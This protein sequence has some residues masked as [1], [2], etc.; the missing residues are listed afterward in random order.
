MKRTMKY[1][2]LALVLLLLGAGPGLASSYTWGDYGT[3]THDTPK[4]QDLATYKAEPTYW[5]RT[6]YTKTSDYGVWWNV[7]G[8]GWTQDTNVVLTAG[9]TV[10]FK[11]NMH[12]SSVGTHYADFAK[13]WVDWGQDGSFDE[14]RYDVGGDVVLF[15]FEKLEDN[16]THWWWGDN[17]GSDNT[18]WNPYFSF[19]SDAIKLTD[20]IYGDLFLRARVT[21][22]ESLGSQSP[23]FDYESN[24]L[25]SGHLYQG[26]TEDWKLTATPVPPSLL[27]F[28]TGLIGF[29]AANRKRFRKA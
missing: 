29:A 24:F 18:P 13:L 9:S 10:Q 26:E 12:K 4:W 16:E 8:T 6:Q 5:G 22:S 17:R 25:A 19:T 2:A 20:S 3:A 28:G 14:G 11:V 21:C 1:A 23:G 7:N 15:D 27:L